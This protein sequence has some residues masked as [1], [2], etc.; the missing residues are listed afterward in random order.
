MGLADREG[1]LLLPLGAP[2]V[3]LFCSL[4]EILQRGGRLRHITWPFG[5]DLLHLVE[6]EATL[7][8]EVQVSGSQEPCLR[9]LS[10]L[11]SLKVCHSPVTGLRQ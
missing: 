7:V 11:E 2:E 1:P 3:D 6:G 9:A 10:H 8:G 5:S 4:L